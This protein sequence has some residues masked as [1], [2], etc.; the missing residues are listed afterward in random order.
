MYYYIFFCA[1]IKFSQK[2]DLSLVVHKVMV[3]ISRAGFIPMR[4]QPLHAFK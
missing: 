1:S 4:G 3:S 2:V